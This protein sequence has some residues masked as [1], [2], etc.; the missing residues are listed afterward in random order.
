MK[1]RLENLYEKFAD[2]EI[3]AKSYDDFQN[4]FI[5]ALRGEKLERIKFENKIEK[6]VNALLEAHDTVTA[7]LK[8]Q[9]KKI[10]NEN[11]ETRKMVGLQHKKLENDID[12]TSK[13]VDHCKTETNKN[14][15]RLRNLTDNVGRNTE[16]LSIV[17]EKQLD[18]ADRVQR[19]FNTFSQMCMFCFYFFLK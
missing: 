8:E 9:A 15:Q 17:Q 18:H 1:T 3:F 2:M 6:Q 5:K 12:H 13:A 16:E 19:M 4:T 7:L 14:F 11:K 10:S